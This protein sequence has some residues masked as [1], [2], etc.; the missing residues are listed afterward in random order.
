[1][2]LPIPFIPA[3]HC[4]REGG[5]GLALASGAHLRGRAKP[6]VKCCKNAHQC[7]FLWDPLGVFRYFSIFL[8]V[9]AACSAP[10]QRAPTPSKCIISAPPCPVQPLCLHEALGLYLLP[11]LR[12]KPAFQ[13]KAA[14][15]TPRGVWGESWNPRSEGVGMALEGELEPRWKRIIAV[16]FER[17]ICAASV[18]IPQGK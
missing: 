2:P 17:C 16:A 8:R 4:D 11:C 9:D 15:P 1:M 13:P 6:T 14:L 7:R 3:A 18:Q 12:L 10:T 5:P